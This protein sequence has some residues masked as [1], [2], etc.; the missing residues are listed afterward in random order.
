MSF[1]LKDLEDLTILE[2]QQAMAEGALTSRCLTAFCLAQIAR[3][4]QQGPALNSIMQINPEALFWAEALDQERRMQGVRGPLHGIPILVKDNIQTADLMP[5]TAGT[6][7]L[8]DYRAKTDAFVTRQL[9]AAGAVILGKTN[10][11]EMANFMTKG[12][13]NGYS[14][15]GGQVRSPYGPGQFDVGGSSSGSGVAVAA[16]MAPGAVGTETSG[17]ILSPA[18]QNGVVGIKP[19]VGLIS[20]TGI[21]PISPTQD[22][23]GPMA[24]TVTDVAVMLGAM[25][26]PDPK[27]PATAKRDRDQPLDYTRFLDPEGLKDARIGV[28]R[29]YYRSLSDEVLDRVETVLDVL[30]LSGAEVL[31]PTSIF[32]EPPEWQYDVLTYE[33]KPALD[34]FLGQLPAWC[35]V[36]TLNELIAFN[37]HHSATALLYGQT[38][39]LA[40]AATSGRLTDPTYLEAL[41][42]DRRWAR[43]EGIDRVMADYALDALL[44]VGN[45]GASITAKAGYPSV[46]VP[47]GL[48][49]RGAPVGITFSGRAFREARLIQLAYAF[50]QAANLR[51]PPDLT[52]KASQNQ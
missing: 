51:V 29:E 48:D 43:D 6:L 27:D 42:K 40:S 13:P 30:R 38:Q 47:M 17:S 5:T 50:E 23:A 26:G 37:L 9:R 10:L 22:T 3:Y 19:T 28:P 7:A 52:P 35:P 36:H 15:L 4:D 41:A 49:G 20:R 16:G 44:F 39:L 11:T 21:I 12:M 1:D 24:R 45:Q 14:A 25:A 2:L 31:D 33:F 32:P 18:S 34:A 8:A 46:S